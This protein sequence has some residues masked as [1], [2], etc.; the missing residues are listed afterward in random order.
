VIG[1]NTR[2]FEAMQEVFKITMPPTQKDV[3]VVGFL[4]IRYK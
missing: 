2:G 3:A 1:N 4:E